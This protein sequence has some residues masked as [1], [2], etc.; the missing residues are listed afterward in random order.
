MVL[1]NINVSE[2]RTIS[3]LEEGADTAHRNATECRREADRWDD[4]GAKLYREADEKRK[5]GQY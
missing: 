3:E 5:P 2:E 4:I 1:E